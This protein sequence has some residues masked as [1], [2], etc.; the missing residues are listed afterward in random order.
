MELRISFVNALRSDLRRQ[1]QP[2]A[3][4]AVEPDDQLIL[5]LTLLRGDEPKEELALTG[6]VNRHVPGN[7]AQ[8]V[9]PLAIA[10]THA[11]CPLP[12]TVAQLL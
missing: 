3:W 6:L 9:A 5:G 8:I 2:A 11:P 1:R 12:I 10:G 4:T 7:E